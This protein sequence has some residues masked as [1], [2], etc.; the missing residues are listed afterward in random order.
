M[1]SWKEAA[2]RKRTNQSLSELLTLRLGVVTG[3]AWGGGGEG[4]CLG[5]VFSDADPRGG[6]TCK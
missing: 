6:C 5:G 3:R 2:W 1:S 4:M